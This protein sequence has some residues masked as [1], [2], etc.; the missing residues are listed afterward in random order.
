[1]PDINHKTYIKVPLEEV[2][3]TVST[4]QGWNA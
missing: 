2:Y 3:K 4:S 1:M